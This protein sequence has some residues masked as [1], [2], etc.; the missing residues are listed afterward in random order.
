MTDQRALDLSLALQKRLRIQ[1]QRVLAKPEWWWVQDDVLKLVAQQLGSKNFAVLDE[2]VPEKHALTLRKECELRDKKGLLKQAGLVNGKLDP[3]GARAAGGQGDGSK[4][5]SYV[6]QTTRGDRIGW[7]DDA[8]WP[9]LE[10]LNQRIGTLVDQLK[11]VPGLAEKT[12]ANGLK[13]ITTRSQNMVACY[14]GGGARYIKHWDNDG[15]HPVLRQR[16]LTALLYLNQGWRAGDGG[17]LCVYDAED[18]AVLKATVTPNLGRLLLFWSDARVPH[19]V[20]PSN[21]IRFSVTTWYLDSTAVSAPSCTD[22][23]VAVA[24]TSERVLETSFPP[25]KESDV[26]DVTSQRTPAPTNVPPQVV[27]PQAANSSTDECTDECA[28]AARSTS[29]DSTVD[30]APDVLRDLGVEVAWP[31]TKTLELIGLQTCPELEFNGTVVRV[32]LSLGGGTSGGDERVV[33]IPVGNLA[34]QIVDHRCKWSSK[35][36]RL[37]VIFETS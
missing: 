16:V 24:D 8:E 19:E 23:K 20:K 11:Q 28:A 30:P 13:K 32:R 25:A 29:T 2:F 18:T 26:H 7:F 17:E 35:R 15:K 14:P 22:E 36:K 1:Y 33:E 5:T 27:L 34:Q 6:E 10:D 31:N 3:V 4:Q 37:Q 21:I 9:V 12:V